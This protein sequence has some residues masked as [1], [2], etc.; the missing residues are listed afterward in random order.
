MQ[1]R[2][3]ASVV[4]NPG[5]TQRRC[6]EVRNALRGRSG[7]SEHDAL[8]A[9]LLTG[10][11]QGCEH[12]GGRNGSRALNVVVERAQPV[13]KTCELGDRVGFQEIFPLQDG[14][15]VHAHHGVDEAIDEVLILESPN[16]LV[17]Q[18]EIQRVVQPIPIVRAHVEHDRQ[19]QRWRDP[20][21]GRVERE[22]SGWDAHPAD[23]LI[24]QP[25][26][27]F[28]VGDDD[29]GRQPRVIPQNGLDLVALIVPDVE[30]ARAAEDVR[31]LLARFA[32]DRRVDDRHHLVDVVME[33]TEEQR[34]VPVLQ[35]GKVDVALERCR[36]DDDSS[37]TRGPVAGPWC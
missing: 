30:T 32:D 8:V 27:A 29:D 13:A 31:E 7:S 17:P 3:R 6:E 24:A 26:N 10:H 22:L 14:V 19:R 2:C 4:G 36:L 1:I 12:T 34:L 25:E 11:P 15:R 5:L 37:G 23:S 21:A 35:A 28:P 33:E 16:P 20:G 18:A 9:H